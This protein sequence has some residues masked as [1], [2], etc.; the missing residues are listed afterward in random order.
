MKPQRFTPDGSEQLEQHLHATCN[1]VLTGV[2]EIVPA[3]DLQALLLG[4][5]YGRGEGG[6]LKTVE[7]DAPYNDLEFYVC[8]HGSAFI[9][10][11]K[12]GAALHQLGERLSPAAKVDVEFK[13]T[14]HAKLKREA[15]TMFFYDLALGHKVLAGDNDWLQGRLPEASDIPLFEATRLLMNRC[16]GLLFSAEKLRH[17]PLSPADADFIGRNQAKAQLA[18]GDVVLT[19]THQYHWSCLERQRRLQASPGQSSFQNGDEPLWLSR[20]RCHHTHGVEFKLHP[21]RRAANAE[22]LLPLQSALRDIA[23]QLWLWLE[24]QRLKTTFASAE[25]YAL[26]KFNKCPE[27]N[28][29]RNILVNVKTFGASTFKQTKLLRYPRERLFN[30]LALLLWMPDATRSPALLKQLQSDLQSTATDFQ[31]LVAAYYQ[32]W[33][34]FN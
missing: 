3:N 19:A 27:A 21:Q 7:G 23:L 33:Q 18:F 32:L 17:I 5:G 20:V 9:N 15:H 11:R 1:A 34:R 31:G 30:A 24:N 12:F 26:S 28:V 4:G 8:V 29:K 22:E 10:E 14:S 6:V 25:D 2:R 16:S 13:V